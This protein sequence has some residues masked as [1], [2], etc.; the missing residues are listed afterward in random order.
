MDAGGG[1]LGNGNTAR[2][3]LG[4]GSH[5]STEDPGSFSGVHILEM[6]AP[7]MAPV[8]FVMEKREVF[9]KVRK[10]IHFAY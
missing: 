6:L 8:G 5:L 7:V 1:Q 2:R 3:W 9:F 4:S 10:G